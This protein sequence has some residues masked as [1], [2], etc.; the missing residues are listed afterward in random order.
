MDHHILIVIVIVIV[1]VFVIYNKK[2]SN[3]KE[4]RKIKEND[5]CKS[6]VKSRIQR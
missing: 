3:T 2:P 5:K 1:I 4:I 6:S